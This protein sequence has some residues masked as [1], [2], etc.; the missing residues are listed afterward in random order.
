MQHPRLRR[1]TLHR[2]AL[3]LLVF[4]PLIGSLVAAEP[5]KKSA[6]SA[7][8]APAAKATAPAKPA[9]VPTPQSP[10]DATPPA[11]RVVQ[12][13]AI[14]VTAAT[15]NS[16]APD[17][18][19]TSNTV[20]THD[21]LE[22]N[23]YTNVSQALMSVV[24][25]AVV[26]TG[27]PGSLTTVFTRGNDGNMTLVTVDGRR[28]PTTLDGAY[29][30]S[31]LTL[32]NVEQIEVV[33][34][35]SSSLQGGNTT[36]G[37]INLVTLSGRGLDKPQSSVSFEGG[38]YGTFRENAQSRGAV[39]DFDYAVSAS[40]E[41]TDN[42]RQN[43][44]YRNKVYRGNF[45]YQITPDVY[46]DVHFGY[47]NANAGEPNNN[48][49]NDPIGRLQTEDW[50]IS[51]EVVAKVTDF[52][53]TR[54]Y[55]THDETRQN[56]HDL[57]NDPAF[58]VNPISQRVQVTTNS[59]DWQNNLQLAHNWT[60]SAGIQVENNEA[61]QY[62]DEVGTRTFENSL[63]NIAGYV[64]S[65]WQPI[66]G[67][68]VNSSLREDKYSDYDG[69]LSWRQGVSYEVAPTK[70]LVHAS[71]SYSYTPPSIQDLYFTPYNNPNL[72]PE[73]A[74]SWEVGFDQ[75]LLDG[76]LTPGAT[77]FHNSITDYVQFNSA[78][79]P[80]NIAHAVTQGAEVELKAKPLDNLQ[81]DFNYTYLT[82]VNEDSPSE[83]RL[84]RRP[85]NSF[86]FTGVWTPLK[87][88]TLSL[89][90][91]WVV[92]REDFDTFSGAQVEAP[93]Y[94]VLRA[95]ATYRIDEHWSLWV[96]GE[97][98][99]DT[100]YQPVLGYPALGRGIYGGVKFSF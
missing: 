81:L 73:K 52:Y 37:V 72:K 46:F 13:P 16:Q 83:P 19:A 70:T 17:T 93:D 40:N 7:K 77:F 58:F 38:S 56:D 90:G 75:P 91:S 9:L 18:T 23:Q 92:G 57:F 50:Y 42:E 89:G 88:V 5:A 79:I 51:P 47:S 28:E 62:D 94:F 11:A 35:P 98:L 84:V 15:R 43:E 86:N 34:T 33:R 27:A 44:N 25:L 4:T 41:D 49:V 87:P 48:L 76:K 69:A 74:L 2:R 67:L 1:R 53:T 95:S 59:V 99:T 26:P 32:D 20:I 85:R 65:E 12:L 71:G 36:G 55:Y 14:V 21:D 3:F 54:L 78:F 30:L 80:S 8:P 39:G 64:E 66:T 60:L 31:N 22:N 96:R 61:Y 63:F 6:S 82:A 97:N 45:G 68:N 24:G 29:D 100:Q 10:A